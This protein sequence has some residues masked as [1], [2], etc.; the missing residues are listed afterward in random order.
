M[1]W[2]LV[3]LLRVLCGI[4]F[5]PHLIGKS[6]NYDKAAG[7]FAAAGFLPGKL[8]VGLTIALE[9]VAATGLVFGVFPRLAAFLGVVVLAGASYAIVKINGINWRWQKMG[10]EFPLFWALVLMLTALG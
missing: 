10:P 5:V 6:L 8:F 1:S 4:W 3:E 2:S 7:T 9:A